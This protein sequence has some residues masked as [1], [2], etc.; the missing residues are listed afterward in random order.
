M[1]SLEKRLKG[2]FSTCGLFRYGFLGIWYPLLVD[3]NACFGEGSVG[4]GRRVVFELGY[5]G[6][7]GWMFCF[8]VI[9]VF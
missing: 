2:G 9:S 8:Y 4:A 7:S 6:G 5:G 1:A 3:L